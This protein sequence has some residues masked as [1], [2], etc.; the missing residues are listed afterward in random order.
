MRQVPLFDELRRQMVE[1]QLR[2]R[3][4]RDERVLAAMSRV[5]REAFVDNDWKYAAYHDCALP[6][7]C[8]QTMSQPY[9]VAYMC[10]A[11][12]ISPTDKVLEIGTGSGYGAAVLSR[13][14]R[15]VYTVER[16]PELAEA[17]RK[18]LVD[19]GYRN[20]QVATAN[21]TLGSPESAPYDAILVTAAAVTLP[22]ALVEQLA[23]GGRIVIPIG[24]YDSGQTMYCFT[25]SDRGL[26]AKDL[27]AFA[28]VPLVGAYSRRELPGP[29][30]NDNL[31][32]G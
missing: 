17:A 18:R 16:V 23:P 19:L 3:G 7:D 15:E 20:V 24:D 32:A 10:E 6:I 30:I 11:A 28:F 14:A 21:G 29:S 5:P 4:I 31:A 8:G 22:E 2:P 27:G 12:A 1:D 26:E 9:T 13:L 25:R